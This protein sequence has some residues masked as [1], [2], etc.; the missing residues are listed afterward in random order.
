[1]AIIAEHSF[2]Q[3]LFRIRSYCG[4]Q[5]QGGRRVVPRPGLLSVILTGWRVNQ[6]ATE[7]RRYYF[8]CE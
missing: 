8:R 2:L 3:H 1:M 4:V 6:T 7:D 5:S